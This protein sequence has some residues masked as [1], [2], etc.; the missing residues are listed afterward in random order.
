MAGAVPMPVSE[1]VW[2]PASSVRVKVPVRVPEA[3]GVKVSETVQPVLAA[4]VGPQVLAVMWKSPVRRAFAG[5]R[6]CRR[7]WRW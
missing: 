2:V 3:V 7:C 5:R 6:W 4:S 1:A